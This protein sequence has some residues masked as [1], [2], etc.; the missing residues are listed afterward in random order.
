MA[1]KTTNVNVTNFHNDVDAFAKGYRKYPKALK[2][3]RG[4]LT[5]REVGSIQKQATK[6][7]KDIEK[8]EKN[9]IAK[10]S[11]QQK[12]ANKNHTKLVKSRKLARIY[13]TRAQLEDFVA[14]H[15]KRKAA[16]KK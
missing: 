3:V 7:E 15:K 9:L 8:I 4:I 14:G 5:Q 16:K 6:L 2:G 11:E 10:K 13:L 1:T 12:F